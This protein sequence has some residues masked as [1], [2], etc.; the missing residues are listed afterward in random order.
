MPDHEFEK[1]I[2][3]K[4]AELRLPP[5]APVW[6]KVEQQLNKKE[7]R[8][9]GVLWIP[10]FLAA[11]VAVFLLINRSIDPDAAKTDA[12]SQVAEAN[13][14]PQ[15]DRQIR[16]NIDT[17]QVHEEDGVIKDPLSNTDTAAGVRKTPGRRIA[18]PVADFATQNNSSLLPVKGVD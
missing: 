18:P 10:F 3:E 15:V 13:S 14:Y 6:D 8:R 17:S 1:K 9:R 7:K 4:M 5:S 12:G 16:Q 11:A 2:Q